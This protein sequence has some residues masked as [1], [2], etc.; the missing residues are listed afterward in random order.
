MPPV[1]VNTKQATIAVC[2]AKKDTSPQAVKGNPLTKLY[3]KLNVIANRSRNMLNKFS[4]AALL[5]FQIFNIC[6]TLTPNEPAINAQP[7]ALLSNTLK[8]LPVKW[9]KKLFPIFGKTLSLQ[10][11]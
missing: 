7:N 6:G 1:Y 11:Y 5:A 4:P 8:Q 9:S 2:N 3:D 10:Y